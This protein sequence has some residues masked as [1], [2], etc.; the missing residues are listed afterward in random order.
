[1]SLF[2]FIFRRTPLGWLQLKHD[3]M[4]LLVAISGITFADI[5]IFMQLGILNA[6][7]ETSVLLHRNLKADIVVLS[8]NSVSLDNLSTFPR[9]RLYQALDVPGVREA[10]P[11]YINS[12][13]WKDPE[14]LDKTSM[15]L[16]GMNPNQVA[17]NLPDINQNL[18]L[19]KLP[20]T[21]LFDK[22]ARGD[23]HN[24]IAKIEAGERVTT[25]IERRTLTV[26][27]VFQM[28]ASFTTD[29]ALIT[30]DQNFLRLFPKRDKGSVSIGLISLDSPENAPLVKATLADYLTS[31]VKVLTLDEF[32]QGEKD[33]IAKNRPMG[34]VFG[35]GAILGFVVGVVI[36]YQILSTD[37][38]DHLEEYAT[39]KAMGFRNIYLLGI[40]FEEAIILA[41]LG[42]VPGLG[43]SLG[44]YHLLRQAT[45]LPLFMPTARMIGVLIA[46]IL[47][48][49]ISGMIAIRKLQSADPAEIF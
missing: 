32:V 6:L 4:R 13:Q 17:F 3:K 15:L 26:G 41:L 7:Y 49:S 25:E 19:L 46:T 33:Y 30:S 8:S 14:T 24:T 37:V 10:A 9:R 27:G 34:F 31:D 42:F 43:V 16:I 40:V 45:M 18:S 29:G 35:L 11:L 23:Y 39:L 47:M 5:L 20:D 48:C 12:I 22:T 2:N 21:L 38:N 1:M 36:V 44:L 28:G